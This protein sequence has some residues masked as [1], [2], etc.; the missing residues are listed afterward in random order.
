MDLSRRYDLGPV[1]SIFCSLKVF[2]IIIKKKKNRSIEV[3]LIGTDLLARCVLTTTSVA[4]SHDS[5]SV[6]QF[7]HSIRYWAGLA[8][9]NSQLCHEFVLKLVWGFFLL[10]AR[11][12]VNRLDL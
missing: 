5:W 7:I 2:K 12:C 8:V 3:A 4:R 9:T 6:A 11:N 10:A 1:R